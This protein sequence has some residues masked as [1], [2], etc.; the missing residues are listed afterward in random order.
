MLSGFPHRDPQQVSKLL[1]RMEEDGL[2]ARVG[3]PAKR[4]RVRIALTGK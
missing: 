3:D 1:E 4:N 2:L